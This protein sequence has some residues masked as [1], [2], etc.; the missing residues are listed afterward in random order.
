MLHDVLLPIIGIAIATTII[1][2]L[3]GHPK[4]PIMEPFKSWI[5]WGVL[6]VGVCWIVFGYVLPDFFGVRIS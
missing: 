1:C 6:A 2:F 3:V 5:W 4:S